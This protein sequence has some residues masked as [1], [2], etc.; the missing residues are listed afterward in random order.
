MID[1][2]PVTKFMQSSVVHFE[3][4]FP[5]SVYHKL[6]TLDVSSEEVQMVILDFYDK[7]SRCYL[8]SDN[9]LQM[10]HQWKMWYRDLHKFVSDGDCLVLPEG[11]TPF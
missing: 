4:G 10:P 5:F 2:D 6:D 7:M 1:G 9:W 3:D 8:C 11:L